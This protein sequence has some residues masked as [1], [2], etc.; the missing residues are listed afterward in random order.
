MAIGSTLYH[1]EIAHK[2][3]NNINQPTTSFYK[4]AEHISRNDRETERMR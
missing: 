3:Y 1:I 4:N 2:N